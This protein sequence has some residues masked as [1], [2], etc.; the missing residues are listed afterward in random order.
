MRKSNRVFFRYLAFG[1]EILL[2]W[3][4]QSTPKL[5]PSLFGEKPFLLLA[6][7]LS[8]AVCSQAVPAVV[9]GAVCGALADISSTGGVGYFSVAFTLV[10]FAVSML[11][12]TYLNRNLATGTVLSIAAIFIVLGLYF[13]FFRLF[14]GVPG[15]GALFVSR[16]LLRMAYTVPVFL[17]LCFLNR[18]LCKAFT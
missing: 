18:F 2:L 11:L 4:L 13:V 12:D 14:A 15:C 16:Y 17:V 1:L 5:M 10:C 9:C 7:A 6:A 3:V 8:I